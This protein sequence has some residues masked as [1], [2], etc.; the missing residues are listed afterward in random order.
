MLKA[1]GAISREKSLS[2]IVIIHNILLANCFIISFSLLIAINLESSGIIHYVYFLYSQEGFSFECLK[3]MLFGVM[4]VQNSSCM[5]NRDL[6]SERLQQFGLVPI[7][8]GGAGD[9]F[10]RAFSH[11]YFDTPDLHRRVR[12][13]GITHMSEYPEVYFESLTAQGYQWEAYL[14]QL[15]NAG[16]WA[17]NIIIQAVSNSLSVVICI[18]H[19]FTSSSQPIIIYPV[20]E[21]R[22]GVVFLGFNPEIHYLATMQMNTMS[23]VHSPNQ[24][25]KYLKEKL[26]ATESKKE[27]VKSKRKLV[28]ALKNKMVKERVLTSD[29]VIF[30]I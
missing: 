6:L 28:Y 20:N 2:L 25:L 9:C 22:Q 8:V 1:K 19:A 18:I 24:K 27:I 10:F 30:G 21:N 29:S 5:E 15:S 14:G 17:D 16:T 4:S 13:L 3:F 11:Q 12:L 23:R 26:K 7:D